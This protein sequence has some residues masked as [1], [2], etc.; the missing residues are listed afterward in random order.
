MLAGAPDGGPPEPLTPP[1]VERLEQL[2]APTLVVVGA[3]DQPDILRAG[4]Q[5]ARRIPAARPALLPATAHLA[6]LEQPNAFNTLML[7]FLTDVL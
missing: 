1:A 2:A 7:D 3:L 4:E 6:S 5:L